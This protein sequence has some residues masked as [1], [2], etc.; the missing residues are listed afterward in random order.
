MPL[1]DEL[2]L[3]GLRAHLAAMRTDREAW[4]H[5]FDELHDDAVR[6]NFSTPFL[7]KWIAALLEK[8]LAALERLSPFLEALY[9]NLERSPG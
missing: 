2:S 9:R 6:S 4:S 8:Q 3:A 1:R 5:R 7:L